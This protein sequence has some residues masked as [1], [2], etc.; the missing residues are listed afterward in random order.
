MNISLAEVY[1]IGVISDNQARMFLSKPAGIGERS[2]IINVGSIYCVVRCT[3]WKTYY[4][5]VIC[6]PSVMSRLLL[7]VHLRVA[8]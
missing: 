5:I 8:S 3:T 2:P 4:L 1:P 7:A 6:Y